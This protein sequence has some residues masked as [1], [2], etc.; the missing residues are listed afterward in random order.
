M[1]HYHDF[2]GMNSDILLAAQGLSSRVETGFKDVRE[3]IQSCESRFSLFSEKSELRRLNHSAGT[4]FHASEDLFKLISEASFYYGQTNGLYDPAIQNTLELAGLNSIGVG[5][6]HSQGNPVKNGLSSPRVSFLDVRMDRNNQS[7]RF[8]PD[9]QIDLNG[10]IKGW[11][12]EKAAGILTSFSDSCVVSVGGDVY[13]IGSSEEKKEWQIGLENPADSSQT[14]AI[15]K[16]SSR[17]AIATASVFQRRGP[18]N[19][20]LSSQVIDPRTGGPPKTD[21]LSVTVIAHHG[22][23]AEVY[24]RTL[25][26]SGSRQTRS[27]ASRTNQFAVIGVD[28]NLKLWGSANSK[29]FLDDW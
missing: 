22:I 5:K 14:L 10:I 2:Q 28:E 1:M 15:L 29:E 27:V 23:L 6:P 21:W 25:L 11:M 16:V 8:P 12:A 17:C 7:V 24:A 18:K 3:F 19:G 4:W 26:I 9:L 13:A 20:N